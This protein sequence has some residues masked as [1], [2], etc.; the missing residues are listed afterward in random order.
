MNALV[1]KFGKGKKMSLT[2]SMSSVIVEETDGQI[3]EIGHRQ[4]TTTI[5]QKPKK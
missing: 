3:M 1:E 5:V 2:T 4:L